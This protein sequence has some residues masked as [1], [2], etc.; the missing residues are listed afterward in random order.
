[1]RYFD[2]VLLFP[3]SFMFGVTVV[4]EERLEL[5]LGIIAISFVWGE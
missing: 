1:M 4:R 3:Y 2:F 5:F